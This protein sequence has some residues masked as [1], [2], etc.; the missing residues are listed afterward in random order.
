[1]R[2][3]LVLVLAVFLAR[4]VA[5]LEPF[6]S[7]ALDAFE[8]LDLEPLELEALEP[9]DSEAL[10]PLDSDA[11]DALDVLLPFAMIKEKVVVL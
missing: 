2:S 3:R 11:L 1:M 5:A 4:G 10:E 9:L 7:E 8:P 6:E